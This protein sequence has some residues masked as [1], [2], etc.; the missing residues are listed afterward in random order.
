MFALSHFQTE[1]R[2]P[3][4]IAL[5]EIEHEGYEGTAFQTPSPLAGE[6]WGEGA[7]RKFRVCGT[8]PHPPRTDLGLARDQHHKM[9]KSGKPD[10]C[11][12]PPL[13]QGERWK[14]PHR[15][16]T[17]DRSAIEPGAML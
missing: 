12:R 15:S 6:S 3:P 8:P 16:A 13:P 11:A 5:R 9:R 1:N 4:P 14:M 2:M 7:R 10:L 17:C